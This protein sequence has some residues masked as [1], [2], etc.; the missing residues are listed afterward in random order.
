MDCGLPEAGIVDCGLPEAVIGRTNVNDWVALNPDFATALAAGVLSL[1]VVALTLWMLCLR[2]S[3]AL[4]TELNE[5]DDR[6]AEL[7]DAIAELRQQSLVAAGGGGTASS[8]SSRAGDQNPDPIAGVPGLDAL[9]RLAQAHREAGLQVFLAES[10]SRAPLESG[11]ELALYRIV[12]TALANSRAHGGKGTKVSVNL[13]WADDGLHMLIEDDGDAASARRGSSHR[14]GASA[15]KS[16]MVVEGEGIA[17]MRQRTNAYGGSFD[18]S[19]VPGVGF[20]VSARFPALP[21]ESGRH[22]SSQG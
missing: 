9:G 11:A 20:R 6:I 17:E 8:P 10:G 21:E 12:E 1:A 19:R 13:G 4:S 2:N 5:A 14:N 3:R 16:T 22:T 18:A 7:E 15:G